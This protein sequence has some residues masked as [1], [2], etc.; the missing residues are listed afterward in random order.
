MK[1]TFTVS[2]E[3]MVEFANILEENEVKNEIVGS[4]DDDSILIDVYYNSDQHECLE[5]LEALAEVEE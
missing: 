2:S 4:V 1:I 5:E 3:N